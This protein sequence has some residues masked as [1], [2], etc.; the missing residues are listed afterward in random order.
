MSARADVKPLARWAIQRGYT[1]RFTRRHAEGVE[2]VATGAQGE[3]HFRYD[4]ATRTLQLAPAT[5]ESGAPARVLHL[6]DYGWEEP[7]R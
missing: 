7:R 6:N 4:P 3:S 1:L 2:G 5:A